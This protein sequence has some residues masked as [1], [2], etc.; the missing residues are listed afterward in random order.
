[1][2]EKDVLNTK[3]IKLKIDRKLHLNK[4]MCSAREGKFI[5]WLAD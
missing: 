1:M 4:S 5:L 3:R 2:N